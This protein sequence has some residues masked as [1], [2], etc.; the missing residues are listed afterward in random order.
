LGSIRQ[1]SMR[2]P[3]RLDPSKSATVFNGSPAPALEYDPAPQSFAEVIALF[4]KRRE[5]LIRSHLW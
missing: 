1:L 4:D 5:A 3:R 2:P